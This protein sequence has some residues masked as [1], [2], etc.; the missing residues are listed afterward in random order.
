M[1]SMPEL[2][3]PLACARLNRSMRSFCSLPTLIRSFAARV[4]VSPWTVLAILS[5]REANSLWGTPRRSLDAQLP[6]SGISKGLSIFTWRG[7]SGYGYSTIPSIRQNVSTRKISS[8]HSPPHRGIC[9]EP[10]RCTS[11]IPKFDVSY[12]EK[13]W[14]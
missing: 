1:M 7:T 2:C 6:I 12:N 11:R 10:Q 8:N 3:P 13:S 9:L 5:I 14:V 4:P